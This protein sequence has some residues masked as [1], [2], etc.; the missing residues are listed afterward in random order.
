ME[1]EKGATLVANYKQ[2]VN[3][4]FV[5]NN[6]NDAHNHIAIHHLME[7]TKILTSG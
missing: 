4:R 6:E 2:K 5:Q 7:G 3:P 1:K